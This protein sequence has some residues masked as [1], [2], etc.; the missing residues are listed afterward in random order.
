[1]RHVSRIEQEFGF[2]MHHY[3]NQ[4]QNILIICLLQYKQRSSG[5]GTMGIVSGAYAQALETRDGEKRGLDKRHEATGGTEVASGAV[6]CSPVLDSLCSDDPSQAIVLCAEPGMGKTTLLTKCLTLRA[7]VG[8]ATRYMDLTCVAEGEIVPQLGE[9]VRWCKRRVHEGRSVVIAIDNMPACDESEMERQV[10]ALRSMLAVGARILM[11]M[12]PEGEGMAEQFGEAIW[13]WSCNL[14]LASPTSGVAAAGYDEYAQGIPILVEALERAPFAGPD[15]IMNDPGYTEAYSKTVQASIRQSLMEEEQ[16]LRSVLL[17]LGHGSFAEVETMLDGVDADLWRSLARDAPLY[18]VCVPGETFCCVGANSAGGLVP[19]QA[20]LCDAVA[21]WPSVICAVANRLACRGDYRRAAFV[22]LMCSSDDDRC[23]LIFSWAAEY[24]DVGELGI[25]RDAVQC[26]RSKGT[27]VEGLA[28][29]ERMVAAIEAPASRIDES[30]CGQEE[31]H[32]GLCATLW[33][34]SRRLYAD[35]GRISSALG[36][37]TDDYLERALACHER[38]V[39]LMLGGHLQEAYKVLS[40]LS[41]P[42]RD[43]TVVASLLNADYT[44]CSMLM[45]VAPGRACVDTLRES[46]EFFGRMGMGGLGGLVNSALPL[47]ALLAGRTLADNAFE[48][49]AHR[50]S[51]MGDTLLQGVYLAA[52]AVADVRSGLLVRA[53]VRLGQAEDRFEKSNATYL[54]K[55]TRLLGICTRIQLGEHVPHDEVYS[56]RGEGRSLN[57]AVALVCAARE[58]RRGNRPVGSGRWDAD[59][60]PRDIHWL[61]NILSEDFGQ[62]SKRMHQVMPPLWRESVRKGASD[63]DA[64][65]ER[66]SSKR[67]GE[68]S[69]PKHVELS[70]GNVGVVTDG[71][72]LPR[73]RVQIRALGGFEVRVDDVV[74]SNRSLER[75]RAKSMLALLAVLPE[76]TAKRFTLMESVWPDYDY[77][78]A[79]RCVYSATSVLRSEICG[80]LGITGKAAV[81]VANKAD[82]TLALDMDVVSCDVDAFE[83]LARK[84]LDNEGD[85]ERAMGLCRRIEEIYRGGLFVPP[86][87]EAGIVAARARELRDLYCDAMIAGA[88]AAMRSNAHMLACRFA[89]R[90][91]EADDMREDAICALVAALNGAGRRVEADQVYERYV[92]R[93]V[94][95]TRRPPSKDLRLAI[96]EYVSGSGAKEEDDDEVAHEREWSHTQIIE[97]K[98]PRRHEQLR[99]DLGDEPYG[100]IAAAG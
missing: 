45:G 33:E 24:I 88:R 28:E 95:M 79:T 46:T 48:T 99:L 43:E 55:A 78:T 94:D 12:L 64:M 92:S 10:R 47:G 72:D 1:M 57:R 89:R 49:N 14:R 77:E 74:L 85:D 32:Q 44:L 60:N 8:D 91:H 31:T 39:R 69:K 17:L 13:F 52:S 75:R 98:R 36:Q 41:C 65:V 68:L 5:V 71:E 93:M 4:N 21:D 27:T 50:A 59:G 76:H 67:D 66:C 56:C 15:A 19:V 96:Q 20:I 86:T 61:L 80:L 70:A 35:A 38:A 3:A 40:A 6:P 7:R 73:A 37:V 29:A 34:A 9:V 30:T 26:V 42:L 54:Q 16:K 58:K 90:A 100:H 84:A 81:I 2:D 87:D 97:V 11:S 22:S 18:G 82:R 23:S 63:V 62:L 51:Y 53:H 83:G 25:V